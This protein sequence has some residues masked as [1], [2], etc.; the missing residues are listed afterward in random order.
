MFNMKSIVGIIFAVVLLTGC[1]N[2]NSGLEGKYSV[3]QTYNVESDVDSEYTGS[4]KSEI[5]LSKGEYD[6]YEEKWHGKFKLVETIRCEEGGWRYEDWG[7]DTH[8]YSGE[9]WYNEKNKKIV[10]KE[11][12]E[13]ED[14]GKIEM[15]V[16]NKGERL[17][18][19]NKKVP[20]NGLFYVKLGTISYEK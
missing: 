7:K 17:T 12:E 9:Y 13:G 4:F 8:K 1:T 5:T 16:E 18:I 20:V 15:K 6:E 14:V 11:K 2:S 19:K 10:L 3:F